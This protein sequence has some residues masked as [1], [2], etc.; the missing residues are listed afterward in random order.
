MLRMANWLGQAKVEVDADYQLLIDE[1]KA[2]E[3]DQG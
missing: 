1:L 2:A 3:G